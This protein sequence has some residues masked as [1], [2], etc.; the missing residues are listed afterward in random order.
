MCLVFVLFP[1]SSYALTRDEIM[2]TA[3]NYQNRIWAPTEKNVCHTAKI[4]TPDRNTYTTW[5]DDKGW[6][7]EKKA[8]GVYAINTGI[9]YN[10]GG[11]S[12]LPEFDT[13]VEDN[14]C[15]GNINT[16]YGLQ[17]NTTGV[18]CS[19]FVSR[20]WDLKGKEN[21]KS[22]PNFLTKLGS[23]G[24]L[25][26]GDIVNS[27]SSHVMLCSE[28]GPAY[29]IFVHESSGT[30]WKVSNRS[31]NVALLQKQN[32]LPYTYFKNMDVELVVDASGSMAGY[33][34]DQA[35]AAAK[36]FVDFMNAG[37][38]IG[39]TSFQ[40]KPLNNFDLT[41][42]SKKNP[43][44]TADKVKQSIDSISAGGG[45]TIGSGIQMAEFQ[46]ENGGL[47]EK[48]Q[49]D[50]V[51]TIILISDG[52]ENVYEG[53]EGTSSSVNPVMLDGS[54]KISFPVSKLMIAP[55]FPQTV[56]E[57]L[58]RIIASN[59]KVCTIGMGLDSNMVLLNDIA[60]R[61]GCSYNFIPQ[62]HQ[63]DEMFYEISSELAGDHTIRKQDYLINPGAT[64]SDTCYIDSATQNAA[65][66]LTWGGSDMDLSLIS[67]DGKTVIDHMT[68]SPDVEF[69]E[70]QTD[71]VYKIQRP[72]TGKWTIKIYGKDVPAGGEKA[73]FL[74][75]GAGGLIFDASADKDEYTEGDKIKFSAY[76]QDSILDN[77]D[78]QYVKGEDFEVEVLS[79]DES[80]SEFKL[81]DDGLHG[82]GIAGDGVYGGEFDNTMLEGNYNFRIKVSGNTNREGDHFTREKPMTLIVKK[83]AN[84]IAKAG[85]PYSGYVGFPVTF[86]AG[87]SF[88]PQ[89]K[90]LQ[91]R[92][93]FDSDG[94]F[95]TAFSTSAKTD[96]VFYNSLSGA[97]TLEITNGAISVT[98]TAT[99][100][101]AGAKDL[102][103][104]ALADIGGVSVSGIID[105][106]IIKSATFF[107][108]E[109]E[110]VEGRFKAD[111]K[112]VG[113]SGGL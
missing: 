44:A 103:K 97:A 42:I 4:D 78:P 32:Y 35:K 28:D 6:K 73:T 43:D 46:L 109:S 106:T 105:K 13:E 70:G 41:T 22:L 80:A 93:D 29:S 30:D 108:N 87:G 99:V 50:P 39:V 91:Y 24:D 26:K 54:G 102:K 15:A 63:L 36:Q 84:P 82:D 110:T 16:N 92:W 81:Y 111:R 64:V 10:W 95:D 59:I 53:W 5:P 57:V 9:P 2:T 3:E 100:N 69:S 25:K 21:T 88:D 85:G 107:I 12:T 90:A 51:R 83:G 11:A 68:N 37:D 71:E 45:S 101:V 60:K 20:V 94:K 72:M 96:H 23:Y 8:D 40:Y 1:L 65:F 33:K 74:A 56:D 66:S 52:W 76:V 104:K 77:D 113:G 14:F 31:Y 112:N 55:Y 86:D 58:P 38:K 79:P 47:D 18:D 89:G 49:P 75:S 19:G 7:W 17:K 98:D 27:Y 62:T 67:P 34:I 48:E 61:T